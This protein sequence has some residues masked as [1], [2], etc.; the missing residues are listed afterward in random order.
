MQVFA[1]NSMICGKR[2]GR[3]RNT[4]DRY[5][6]YDGFWRQSLIRHIRR[7]CHWPM[8]NAARGA[9][10]P[11]LVIANQHPRVV[12]LAAKRIRIATPVC[13]LVRNDK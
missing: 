6:G 3:P 2:Q 11:S 12:S 10:V 8:S 13:A 9:P 4:G 1:K 7:I 5:D